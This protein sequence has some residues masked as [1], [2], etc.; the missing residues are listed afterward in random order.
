[1]ETVVTIESLLTHSSGLP[2]ESDYP[3][4][5]GP[6]FPFP[7][8]QQMIEKLKTQSTLYPAQRHYQYSNLAVSLAG[9]VVQE[10]VFDKTARYHTDIL[11]VIRLLKSLILVDF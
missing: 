9:E 2:R 11:W 5:G 1:M 7:T 3:Y 10:A 8:R 6:D 4:W